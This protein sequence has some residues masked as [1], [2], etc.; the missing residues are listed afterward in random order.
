MCNAAG[1]GFSGY[2]EDGAAQWDLAVNIRPLEFEVCVHAC[3]CTVYVFMCLWYIA[4]KLKYDI[5]E[6]VR[7]TVHS[8]C[9]FSC[10]WSTNV[11]GWCCWCAVCSQSANVVSILERCNKQMAEK[12]QTH[13]RAHTHAR[14]HESKHPV[15]GPNQSLMIFSLISYPCSITL[16]CVCR[17]CF[18][19]VTWQP[20]LV[21]FTF[22]ALWHGFYLKYYMVAVMVTLVVEAARKVSIVHMYTRRY[23]NMYLVQTYLSAG[24][25]CITLMNSVSY[26]QL[27]WLN[28]VCMY[29]AQSPAEDKQQ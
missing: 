28:V 25:V 5:D 27:Q 24:A 23:S 20:T 3:V 4:S 2:D 6:C 21:T 17:V 9:V 8:T 10:G 29:L 14:M 1:L 26:F 15:I 7:S 22:C 12:V 19:R 13:T 18:E 11:G 16:H